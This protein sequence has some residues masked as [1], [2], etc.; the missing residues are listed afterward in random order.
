MPPA[1]RPPR[2][3]SSRTSS[4]GHGRAG[5][6][7][8]GRSPDLLP[9]A[10]PTCSTAPTTLAAPWAGCMWRCAKPSA[11]RRPAQPSWAVGATACAPTRWRCSSWPRRVPRRCAHPS[12]TGARSCWRRS[13]MGAH[14]AGARA[15]ASSSTASASARMRSRQP[16]RTVA[17]AASWPKA[18]RSATCSRPTA[19]PRSSALSSRSV[20]PPAASPATS[21]V[22]SAQPSRAP[23]MKSA[24]TPSAVGVPPDADDASGG[25]PT[26]LGVIA[27]FIGGARE[28]WAL[29]TREVAGLAAGGPTD[30]LDSAD[31][32][33]SAVGRLHVA[34]REA[35]GQEAAGATVLRGWRDRMRADALAVLELATARAPTVCAPILDRRE[36]LLA[37]FEEVGELDAEVPLTRVHGDLHLG[38]VLLDPAG[39][40]RLLDFE[41]EPARSL[42]E[43]RR[44][45]APLRD[46]AGMLRS[47]DYA[48]GPAPDRRR[49]RS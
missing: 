4:A 6:W 28:G 27:D 42:Q 14:T 5:R 46:V 23:P 13:R 48:C 38:Q 17:P 45:S 18:S 1:A 31:D 36:E 12:W 16:R 10:L 44:H 15:V 22:A 29:A 37:R 2:S 21:L 34:L 47:F 49:S 26:A 24:M 3:V 39:V 20:G 43:R 19:L 30:L 33:G 32:L 25:T 35:F 9:E 11:R 40:W 8:P 41:G 7:P